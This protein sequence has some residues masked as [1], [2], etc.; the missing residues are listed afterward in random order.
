MRKQDITQ[1]ARIALLCLFGTIAGLPLSANQPKDVRSSFENILDIR[2]TPKQ[3]SGTKGLFTDAGSWMGFTIPANDSINGFCG[4]FDIDG[5]VWVSKSFAQVGVI[6][7]QGKIPANRFSTTSSSYIPGQINLTGQHNDITVKQ[8]LQF[9]DKNFALLTLNANKRVGWTINSELWLNTD[10]S[11]KGNTIVIRLKNG[12]IMTITFPKRFTVVQ[13]ERTYTATCNNALSTQHVVVGFFTNQAQ[14]TKNGAFANT[15]LKDP[16][17]YS[18]LSAQRWNGYLNKCLREDMNADAN[19]IAAKSI[20][21]LISNWRSAKG[22]LLHDGVV[23]SHAVGYFVGLWAWDSWK[24]AVALSHFEPKLAKNQIR[25]MFDYQLEDGMVIDCIY[26]DKKENNARDSKP[27]LA[28]WCV[29]EVYKQTKDLA[30]V[31]EMFPKLVKYNQWWYKFRDHNR[32]GICEFGAIDGT[33]EAAKWESGMDNAVRYD[34]ATMVKNAKDA[35]SFN[36]ESVDLNAYLCLEAKLLSE[37]AKLIGTSYKSPVESDKINSAFF[38]SSKGY[39]YDRDLNG[40]FIQIE[41]PEGWIPLW[42]G[43]ASA[44]NA[45]SVMKVV[46]DS[47]KFATYIPFP[48]LSADNPKFDPKGYWRGP[49][50]LDQVYFGISGIRKY[51]YKEEA[52]SFTMQVFDR[53]NG[54]KTDAPIH[55][56]Y[57]THTGERLKAPHFS[58]SAAHLLMLYW[59]YKR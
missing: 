16:A 32:N 1:R 17:K 57:G 20:V 52:D 35:W 4:P 12:E 48:T 14:L 38:D 27:P 21:T 18:Q 7:D 5:R 46:M 28:A 30:F 36:Q 50:W 34:D 56:N 19:R 55:E 44:T 42:A 24:H 26:S 8:T 54:L 59:E 6:T 3:K 40:K 13:K 39:Y 45:K 49:I 2:Y 33:T 41:G 9:I 53:L 31:K 22:D 15:I 10:A 47:T 29:M 51:G 23:P 58:W 25:A 43:I 11:Y 37:M